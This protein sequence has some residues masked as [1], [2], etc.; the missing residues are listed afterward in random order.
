MSAARK[1]VLRTFGYMRCDDFASYLSAMAAK[2]WHF[3]EWGVGLTFEK[4]EPEQAVY[5]V[6]CTTDWGAKKALRNKLGTYYVRYENLL[7]ELNDDEDVDL[8]KEQI[9]II[10]N[11]LELR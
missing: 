5:A 4:G 6:D 8:A 9:E 10:R 7:L 11:N 2:G 3:K 1:T